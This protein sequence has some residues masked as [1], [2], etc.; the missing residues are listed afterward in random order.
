MRLTAITD[1]CVDQ[2]TFRGNSVRAFKTAAIEDNGRTETAHTHAHTGMHTHAHHTRTHTTT[3]HTPHI[4][5]TTTTTY[6][7]HTQQAGTLLVWQDWQDLT[8][9]MN[10]THTHTHTCTHAH[11]HAHAHTHTHTHTHTHRDKLAKVERTQP[12]SVNLPPQPG[13]CQDLKQKHNY[14]LQHQGCTQR[15]AAE[16]TNWAL[17]EKEH[18]MPTNE[19]PLNEFAVQ[20]TNTETR[21]M[22][23]THSS[24][25]IYIP[26][27]PAISACAH[28]LECISCGVN[29][30]IHSWL[31]Q[32]NLTFSIL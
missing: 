25:R 5:T 3:T 14:P 18:P 24:M 15:S 26:T 7:K 31:T 23:Y 32:G 16:G 4:H 22:Q 27:L 30:Q 17:I 8:G 2:V 10:G 9:F 21:D 11:A 12:L 29:F 13:G 19:R 6:K 1:C 20:S 28:R